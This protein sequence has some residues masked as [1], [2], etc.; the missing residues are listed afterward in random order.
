MR[1]R[2]QHPPRSSPRRP[3][4]WPPA[5]TSPWQS[6]PVRPGARGGGGASQWAACGAGCDGGDC[7]VRSSGGACRGYRRS[8]C[9]L[10]AWLR[11]QAWQ[12]M[13]NHQLA[14]T[15]CALGDGIAVGPWQPPTTAHQPGA[16]AAPALIT[17]LPTDS[18]QASVVA[19]PALVTA[20]CCQPRQPR[21]TEGPLPAALR[22]PHLQLRQLQLDSVHPEGQLLPSCQDGHHL[23]A[24]HGGVARRSAVR[25]ASCSLQQLR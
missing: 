9:C 1:A 17:A 4:P 18:Q 3:P 10:A 19:A 8:C 5:C 23:R 25:P 22:A 11:Q 6:P 20:P 21:S 15:A 12:K 14:A 16:T 13:S 2:A 7:A 24:S